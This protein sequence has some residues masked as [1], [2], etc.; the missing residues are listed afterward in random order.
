MS[1]DERPLEL[2]D[3]EAAALRA[4]AR[5]GEPADELEDRVVRALAARGLVRRPVALRRFW[6]AAAA[7]IVALAAGFLAGRAGVPAPAA[8]GDDPSPR[9][10]L[11]LYD[12]PGRDATQTPEEARRI[13]AEYGAWARELDRDGR[14]VAGDPIHGEARLLRRAGGRVEVFPAAAPG[15]EVVV[16]Y[17]MIRARDADEALE[18]ARGCPHLAYDGS[19][20]V[21]R[22]GRS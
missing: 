1:D 3:E 4:L 5:D 11:L 21:R 16:G 22:V 13:A 7:A 10:M 20:L 17:F 12:D 9:F 6:P 15:G 8:P 18:I 14:F 19:V 2:T